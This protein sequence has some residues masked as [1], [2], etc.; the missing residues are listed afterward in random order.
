MGLLKFG[1]KLKSKS[2]LGSGAFGVAE[3]LKGLFSQKSQSGLGRRD[4]SA[5][6]ARET[7]YQE[8][9]RNRHQSAEADKSY[10]QKHTADFGDNSG[11][12]VSNPSKHY[13]LA[14]RTPA[15]TRP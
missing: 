5:S 3:D 10:Y 8:A 9:E 2:S 14:A 12:F 6:Q 7:F 15:Q 13:G 4:L 11:N 1:S